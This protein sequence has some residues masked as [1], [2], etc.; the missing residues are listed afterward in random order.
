MQ[1]ARLSILHTDRLYLQKTSLVLIS[2]TATA[3]LSAKVRS[4]GLSQ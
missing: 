1:A 4:D 3:N 2:V